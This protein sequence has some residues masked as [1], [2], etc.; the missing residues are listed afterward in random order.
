MADLDRL[1]IDIV[2]QDKSSDTIDKISQSIRELGQSLELLNVSKVSSLAN[3]LS[4]LASIGQSTRVT[5]KAIKDMGNSLASH[6]SITSKKGIDDITESLRA[7]YEAEKMTHKDNSSATSD[8]YISSI[9][10]VNKAIEA[11]YKYQD[12]ISD[13]AQKV[14][15]FMQAEKEAG[16]KVSLLGMENEVQG[17]E[18]L[19][20]VLGQTFTDKAVANAE[21]LDSFFLRLKEDVPEEAAFNVGGEGQSG[22][23]KDFAAALE[24]LKEY[25]EEATNSELGF[26]E[27]LAKQ[28]PVAMSAS[29]TVD[30][31]AKKIAELYTNMETYGGNAQSGLGGVIGFVNL[32]NNANIPDISGFVQAA[33]SIKSEPAQETAKAVVDV[34]TSADEATQKVEVTDRAIQQL[35]KD[36]EDLKNILEGFQMPDLARGLGISNYTLDIEKQYGRPTSMKPTGFVIPNFDDSAPERVNESLE[37]VKTT[38]LAVIEP[39]KKAREQVEQMILACKTAAQETKNVENAAKEGAVATKNLSEGF[40]QAE[41]HIEQ[42]MRQAREYKKTISDM[43]SGKITFDKNAYDTLVKGYAD[44]TEAVKNYKNELLGIED[45]PKKQ[46]GLPTEGVLTNLMEL[47]EGLEKVS[48]QFDILAEKHI[49]VFKLLTTPLKMVADE[50]KEKFEGMAEKVAEFKKNMQA[51]LTK[52]SQFWKRTMKTFTFMLVRKAITAII[53]EVGNAIQSL[54][55]YSNAMG[56]AFNTDISNMVADFQ[57]LGRSIV[58]VFAPLLNTIAPIIDAITDRIA[59]LLSYIGMLIAALGGNSTF[60]KAKKNV[61]NYAESLDS[62]SKSAKNLTMG[63]D[64]LNILNE[65]KGGGG[66]K[67]YDGWENAWEEVDIPVWIRD[68]GDWLKD[69]WS[70][71]F[72][73]LK[74][75]WDR[76]KQYLIDGFKTMVDSLKRMF[77]SIID[78]FLEMWNQEETIKMFEQI[79]KIVGDIERVIRN[80][81][82]NFDEAWNRGKVGLQIFENL[83]DI[84]SILVDHVRNVSYYMIDWS[85]DVKFDHI[86]E[87]FEEVTNKAKRVADFVG[88]VFED[89]AKTVLDYFEWSIEEGTPH[90]LETIGSIFDAFDFVK[91]RANLKKIWNA[92]EDLFKNI[93]IGTTNAIGNLGKMVARFTNSK[94]FTDF[95]QRVVDITKLITKERVEKVLTGLGKGILNIAESVVK[96]VN[97]DAFMKFLEAIAKWIDNHSVDQIA[98]I[99]EKIAIAIGLFKFTSFTA[100]KLSG[101]FQF[102][103]TLAALKNLGTIAKHFADLGEESGNAAPKITTFAQALGKLKGADALGAVKELGNKFLDLHNHIGLL[104][105]VIG[106]GVT[107]FAEF[108][109]VEKNVENLALAINGDDSKSLGGSILGLVGTLAIAAAAFTA[110]L[111][112]PAG[113]IAAGCVGAVAAIKGISDAIEQI[114]FEHMTDAIMTQGDTTVSRAREWYSETTAIVSEYTSRWKDIER[115]LTQDRGDIEA[116][117]SSLQGLNIAIQNNTEITSTM[118]DSLVGKYENLGNA[119]SNYI[120]KST[121][122]IVTSLLAQRAYL[123]SQGESTEKIDRMIAEIY[124]NADAEKNAITGAIDNLREA[125]K[126]YEEEVA[127]SGSTSDE[128]IRLYGEYVK[129]ASDAGEAVKNFISDINSVDPSEAISKIEALGNSL[130]LS[131]YTH[132]EEGLA[133]AKQDIERN[134]NEI[135]ETFSTEMAAVNKTYDDRVKELDTYAKEHPWFTDEM[136]DESIANIKRE[137]TE[138]KDTL[139]SATGEALDFYSNSLT[140]NFAAVAKK[141]EE[142]WEKQSWWDKTFGVDKQQFILN[143]IKSYSDNLLTGEDGL[144]GQLTSAYQML[145]DELPGNIDPDVEKAMNSILEN[146]ATYFLENSDG[147]KV[148]MATRE[149][150]MLDS[151]LE[152]VNEVDFDTPAGIFGSKE[153]EAI[154]KALGNIKYDEKGFKINSEIGTSLTNN[155]SQVTAPAAEVAREISDTIDSEASLSLEEQQGFINTCEDYGYNAGVAMASGIEQAADTMK[156]TINWWFGKINDWIHGGRDGGNEDLEFGSPNKKTTEYGRETV[157]G[158]NIGI[159][160]SA[161]SSIAPI[162][163]WF[164]YINAAIQNGLKTANEQFSSFFNN[165]LKGDGIDVSGN[166]GMLFANI[167]AAMTNN[168]TALGDTLLMTTIPNFIQTY[169]VPGFELIRSWFSEEAMVTWWTEDVLTMFS[170]D[171]WTEDIFAPMGEFIQ[172]HW[173]KFTEWWDKSIKDWWSKHLL[174][175]WFKKTKWDT[176]IFKPLKENIQSHWKS[177]SEWWDESI[178]NWWEKHLLDPWFKKTKWDTDVFNPLKENIEKHWTDFLTWWDKSIKTF[179]DEHLVPWLELWL[180]TYEKLGETTMEITEKVFNFVEG[181]ISEHINSAKDAV[182]G[183]CGEMQGAIAATIQA[184]E[185]LKAALDGLGDLGGSVSVTFDT[186]AT[187][188]FP[189]GDLFLANEAG[190]EL[191]GTVGGRTAVASNQEITGIADAVYDTGNQEAVLLRQLINLAQNM[192]EKDP[193]VI[194]DKDIARMANNGHS[195]LGMSIIT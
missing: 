20:E 40:K 24:K 22:T 79:F 29:H 190:A 73:P 72:D 142:D 120:D 117:A 109:L 106:T 92:F 11:H 12:V 162:N 10:G 70:R 49:K 172:A 55:M 119:I 46:K 42:A 139:V 51:H 53:K 137:T 100:E 166:I 113:I 18:K 104:P 143:Q 32:L 26:K 150:E 33:K 6:F 90:L 69:F 61:T 76:A 118:A 178:K 134:I 144:A 62:A 115:D 88:G 89:L 114:N 87:A 177:F 91:L 138:A 68:I 65:N 7:L 130:D 161:S 30:E 63:I 156:T 34:A 132:D 193:V 155:V 136:Y 9:A 140:D 122:S 43:E 157:E 95:I 108:K 183:A 1:Q 56:T 107:A 123:E 153:S 102:A 103:T 57:Y 160:T 180:E 159:T 66:A 110:L 99:L 129:A 37:Q 64:E 93:H 80:L 28:E 173:K 149:K 78:D 167:T 147:T 125:Y 98:G 146:E 168:I 39:Y 75:A 158:F 101:F 74:E 189:S 128:A 44:A 94:T 154:D 185:D 5:S 48:R 25:L 52:L 121:D 174:E 59:T 2:A 187:G 141:A 84:A 124:Q 165:M 19:K 38:A 47:G 8:M 195:Q 54:A 13:T 151:V 169:L 17:F 179:W 145:Y 181:N 50:Y 186:Y 182:V 41:S 67:P 60:T 163:T 36:S 3:S 83:R 96:F 152:A 23:T 135:K 194:G 16:H 81:A 14:V 97:S 85:K 148:L 171:K 15:D 175:P 133:A 131:Q 86:L 176:D 170:D 164:S 116:Y 27:A 111:G 112:F 71:F 188:G 35:A 31:Y 192:L 58:S 105:K 184:I 82:D 21:S 4:K 77:G 45:K 126:A 191:V 127:K